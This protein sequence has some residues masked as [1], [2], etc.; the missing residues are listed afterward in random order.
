MPHFVSAGSLRANPY[1][2]KFLAWQLRDMGFCR[3]NRNRV[4]P[5]IPPIPPAAGA[6]G[7]AGPP[8]AQGLP[9]AQGIQGPPGPIAPQG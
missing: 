5:I 3:W 7:P 6:I 1:N 2:V 9:G 8:G 4:F